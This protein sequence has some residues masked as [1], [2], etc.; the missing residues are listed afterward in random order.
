MSQAHLAEVGVHAPPLEITRPEQRRQLVEVGLAGRGEAAQQLAHGPAGEPDEAGL[1]VHR[2]EDSG[3]P[4]LED[5]LG[6]VDPVA[7]LDVQQM[8]AHLVRRPGIRR[9]ASVQP[10]LPSACSRSCSQH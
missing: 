1:A 3:C 9:L 7:L 8:T 4:I 6:A 2:L 5:H 10:H